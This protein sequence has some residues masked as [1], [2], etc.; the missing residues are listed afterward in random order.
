VVTGAEIF[1]QL[2]VANPVYSSNAGEINPGKHCPMPVVRLM[3]GLK[4]PYFMVAAVRNPADDRGVSLGPITG[5]PQPNQIASALEV[6]EGSYPAITV[7]L[8]HLSGR[9]PAIPSI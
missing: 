2:A 9:R 1:F 7:R 6:D 4:E 8:R 3:E 5:P